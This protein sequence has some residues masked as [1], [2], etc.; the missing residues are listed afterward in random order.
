MPILGIGTVAG[1]A[2]VR[3]D[4]TDV[5]VEVK[6]GRSVGGW[7]GPSGR[8]GGGSDRQHDRP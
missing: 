1:E 4:R 7:L 5:A 3:Q 2:A 6:P 8:Q